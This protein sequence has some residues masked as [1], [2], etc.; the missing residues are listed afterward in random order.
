MLFVLLY[1]GSHIWDVV[2]GSRYHYTIIFNAFVWCQIFN[3]FN[4]RKVNNGTRT[5]ST[6]PGTRL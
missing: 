4:A 1:L 2:E 3:L 6:L 5:D